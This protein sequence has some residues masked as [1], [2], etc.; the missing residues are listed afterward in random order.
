[1]LVQVILR[2]VFL[3]IF[4]IG[5][6]QPLL[7]RPAV[8]LQPLGSVD[9]ATVSI[10]RQGIEGKF[11]L[12]V[13]VLNPVVLPSSAYYRPRRRYR[14][15]KLLDFLDGQ[16]DINYKKI[17]GLTVADVSTTKGD[18]PDWGIFGLAGIGGRSCVVSTYRLGKGKVKRKLFYERLVKVVNHELG[19]TLGIDHC[20]V[21]G[22]L[23]ED[24]AGTIRTVDR[25]DGSFCAGCR[26]KLKGLLR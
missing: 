17:V 13:V 1:M 8:A 9:S 23:M 2:V 26:D 12:D 22:C 21:P 7:A 16:G 14:A 20:P 24:A 18:I 4:A 11:D 5:P 25:E 3:V 6:A 15:E 10:A 19:H